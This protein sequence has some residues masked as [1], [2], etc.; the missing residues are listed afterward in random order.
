MSETEPFLELR[1]AFPLPDG[2]FIGMTKVE[3]E[4]YSIWHYKSNQNGGFENRDCE[5]IGRG[6]VKKVL[7]NGDLIVEDEMR[8]FLYYQEGGKYLRQEQSI[9][10]V[11]GGLSRTNIS[12]LNNGDIMICFKKVAIE[13]RE[14]YLYRREKNAFVQAEE[15]IQS[16]NKDRQ[17][18]DFGGSVAAEFPDG[19]LLVKISEHALRTYHPT[20]GG[21]YKEGKVYHIINSGSQSA[22]STSDGRLALIDG[23]MDDI[24]L[25]SKDSSLDNLRRNIDDIIKQETSQIGRATF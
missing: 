18:D 5:L 6:K 17:G 21:R 7:P 8:L 12:A 23:A 13:T 14:S 4:E 19:T 10:E 1:H 16:D 24:V 2:N 3:G 20:E 9:C 11:R 22:T 15:C 25:L